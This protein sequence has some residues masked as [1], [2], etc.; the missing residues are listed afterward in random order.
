VGG[1]EVKDDLFADTGWEAD[2]AF[3]R[4]AYTLREDDDDFSQANAMVN[5]VFDA[6]QRNRL[7]ETVASTLGTVR[8]DIKERVFDY[9]RSIDKAVGD[10]IAELA[11]DPS[12]EAHGPAPASDDPDTPVNKQVEVD[13]TTPL[14][15]GPLPAGRSGL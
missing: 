8:P 14:N 12:V 3:V 4:Q 2:G 6:D 11:A 10:H 5:Q 9:W 13:K 15:D 1:P 7:A